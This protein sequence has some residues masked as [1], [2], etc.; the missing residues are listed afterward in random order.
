[1]HRFLHS[2]NSQEDGNRLRDLEVK[3]L[4]YLSSLSLASRNGEAWPTEIKG[5]GLDTHPSTAM[6][7]LLYL[8]RMYKFVFTAPAV[9]L[10]L[11]GTYDAIF[12]SK[13]T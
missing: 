3:I 6:K 1:M 13:C 8:Y 5:C 4:T 9:Q 7:K 2:H 12:V 11:H 10:Y